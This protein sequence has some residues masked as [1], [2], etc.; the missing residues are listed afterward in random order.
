[1]TGFIK[2]AYHAYFGIK[3]DNQVNM[4]CKTCTEYQRRWTKGKE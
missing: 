3:L 2:R 1:M 4:V